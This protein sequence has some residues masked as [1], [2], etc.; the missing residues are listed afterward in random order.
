[1]DMDNRPQDIEP[2]IHTRFFDLQNLSMSTVSPRLQDQVRIAAREDPYA[3][4]YNP[5]DTCTNSGFSDDTVDLYL[6]ESLDVDRHVLPVFEI[7]A[8]HAERCK[9][10]HQATA[11]QISPFND[12]F[13]SDRSSNIDLLEI[14]YVFPDVYPSPTNVVE[15]QL[16]PSTLQAPNLLET[17]GFQND[18]PDASAFGMLDKM[19]TSSEQL[20]RIDKHL[21]HPYSER[22]PLE[23][24]CNK[25]VK[26]YSKSVWEK[27]KPDFI[28]HYLNNDMDLKGVMRKLAQDHQFYPK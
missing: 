18:D 25:K 17:K 21:K 9:D 19:E 16:A 26:Q 27:I 2:N 22:Q 1:M 24:E 7:V 11:D 3:L 13:G 12:L 23:C 5:Q 8:V 14:D 4:S 15:M 28:E 6:T 10:S 20:K